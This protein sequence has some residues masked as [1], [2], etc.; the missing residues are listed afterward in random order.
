MSRIKYV[1]LLA[2][3][4]LFVVYRLLLTFN[5]LPYF[6]SGEDIT[7][8]LILCVAL[9]LFFIANAV[10]RLAENLTAVH[11]SISVNVRSEGFDALA[12]ANYIHDTAGVKRLIGIQR[13]LTNITSVE[14]LMNKFLVIT[15]KLTNSERASIM[16]H[17]RR[18]DELFIYKTIGWD[19]REIHMVKK[20]K[21]RPG[22]G[23]AGRVFLD[24]E[25][26]VVNKTTEKEDLDTKDKYKSK[27]FVSFPVY[28][29]STIIGVLNLTEKGEANYSPNEL[30][31]IRY[32]I[33]VVA[34][35]LSSFDITAEL[36]AS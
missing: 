5:L 20:M 25:L 14:E 35:K 33:G 21:S 4:V 24:G 32:I 16:L 11:E 6:M 26:L 31:I 8:L 27:S 30:D 23:I 17:D 15:V 22:E 12:L 28:E 34:L 2:L 18:R 36:R 10:E 1:L 29:G 19:S 13:Y 7:V 9:L 3:I